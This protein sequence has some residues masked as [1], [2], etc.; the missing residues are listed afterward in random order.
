MSYLRRDLPDFDQILRVNAKTLQWHPSLP[1]ALDVVQFEEA[2]KMA[3]S[4][5]EDEARTALEQALGLY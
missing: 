2:I 1:L 5:A 3:R 4:P